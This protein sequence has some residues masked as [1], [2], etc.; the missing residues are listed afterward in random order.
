MHVEL[1]KV[2]NYKKSFEAAGFTRPG[3]H[4]TDEEKNVMNPYF[5]IYM[6]FNRNKTIQSHIKR[7]NKY[8]K[9]HR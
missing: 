8:Q 3:K 9:L 2:K 1:Y 6:R 4:K 5:N 7:V